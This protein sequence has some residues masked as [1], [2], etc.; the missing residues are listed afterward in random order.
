VIVDPGGA[1][2]H[3]GVISTLGGSGDY[4][5]TYDRFGNALYIFETESD[6][7]GRIVKLQ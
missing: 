4:A 2:K 7:A 1:A 6:A 3:L 5:V